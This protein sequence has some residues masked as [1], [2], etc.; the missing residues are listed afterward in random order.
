MRSGAE[1]TALRVA[2]SKADRQRLQYDAKRVVAKARQ[3]SVPY[4]TNSGSRKEWT[5]GALLQNELGKQRRHI[6]VRDLMARASSAITALTPC[7]MMSPLTVAQYLKPGKTF[8]DLIIMDEASQVK[9]EDAVGALLRGSQAVIVGDPKQLP[10]TN[11]FDRALEDLEP[12]DEDETDSQIA[13]D[14]RVSAE[15]VLDLG[16][17]AFQPVRRLRWHYRSQHE[18]LIAFSNRQFYDRALVVFPAREEPSESLGIEFVQVNG[19]WQDRVNEREAKEIARVVSGFTRDHSGLSCGIVAMNQPQRDLI[20]AEVDKLT[21]GDADYVSYREHW[22]ERLEPPF[23]KNLENVQGDERDV[24]FVSLGWGRTPEGALHQRF[25]PVN[26]RADGHRRLNVLFTRA[27]RKVVIFSSIQPE[28]I[29][30]DSEKTAPGVRVLRDYLLYARDGLIER[31]EDEEGEAD[32]PF[33]SSVAN[34]LRELGFDVAQQVGVAGYRIDLAVRHPELRS[35]FVLGIECDGA[36]YHSAKSAR[37][38]DRLRQ[39]ALERLG[40]RLTRVW[41]TDWFTDPRGQAERLAKEITAAIRAEPLSTAT[42]VKMVDVPDEAQF[43]AD[44]LD[45]S[46]NATRQGPLRADEAETPESGPMVAESLRQPGR[47]EEPI[48]VIDALRRFRDEVI[49]RDF[50]GSEPNRCI[51]REAMIEEIVKSYLDTPEDFHSKIPQWLRTATDGR[52][53]R[54]LAEICEIVAAS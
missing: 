14:D 23:V 40:W 44:V 50:P 37:D 43:A 27:K 47:P 20:Q 17:R 51:L 9:P 48:N 28:D 45:E 30:V 54:Y 36:S 26:R 13:A 2:F 53:M 52:Q 10:P 11:F 1:L 3:R 6:P 31:G 5:D 16:M 8:F 24:I 7:L 22:E 29:V 18:S 46:G 4:G 15:S 32:S 12:D 38:R 42:K 33:E 39:E 49:L 19:Q 25:F 41:S 21:A 35:R 34:A